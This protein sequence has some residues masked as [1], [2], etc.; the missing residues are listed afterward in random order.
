MKTI[1]EIRY[2]NFLILVE[3]AGNV[4]RFAERMKKSYGQF[5]QLK[6]KSPESKTGKP[7]EIGSKQAREMEL[8]FG[9]EVGWMD[10]ESL[11]QEAQ[12]FKNLPP[13]VRAWILKNA[14]L[15]ASVIPANKAESQPERRL[16]TE[17]RRKIDLG[18]DPERRHLYGAP[19]FTQKKQMS[20]DRRRKK[21]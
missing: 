6:N 9:R 5:S 8:V 1:E 2:E 19:N 14:E 13:E 18:F 12:A 15:T 16:A 4:A 7:K 17:A 20:T 10:H 21:T 11:D 3:E